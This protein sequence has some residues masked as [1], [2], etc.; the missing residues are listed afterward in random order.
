MIS[1]SNINIVNKNEQH[2]WTFL[3][4]SHILEDSFLRK[5]FLSFDFIL[6][7]SLYFFVKEWHCNSLPL[8]FPCPLPPALLAQ[9][10]FGWKNGHS[11]AT[12][13]LYYKTLHTLIRNV[14][15]IDRF[16]SE[17]VFLLELVTFTGLGK[18]ASWLR[19]MYKTEL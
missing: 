9:I 4:Q 15:K 11:K 7:H 1:V 5:Q 14:N 18:Q 19:N 10:S 17:V 8:P 2:L 3:F 12:M 6:S 16:H 13:G